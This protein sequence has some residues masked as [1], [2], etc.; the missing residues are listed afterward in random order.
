MLIAVQRYFNHMMLRGQGAR[1]GRYGRASTFSGGNSESIAAKEQQIGIEVLRWLR[2]SLEDGS[3]ALN[4]Q[5]L[6]MVP[7]GLL[8]VSREFFDWFMRDNPEY[9]NRQTVQ[10]GFLSLGMHK[11]GIDGSINSRFEQGSNQQMHSGILLDD[12]AVALP[13]EVQVNNLNTGKMDRVKATQ[14]IHQAQFSSNNFSSQQ[15]AQA[16]NTLPLLDASGKWT[17][18]PTVRAQHSMRHGVNSSG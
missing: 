18:E 2:N 9:K 12:Y 7:G 6:L 5:P 17:T 11:L 10:N 15:A 8:V 1:G 4:K 13:D 3:L 16:S 14:V